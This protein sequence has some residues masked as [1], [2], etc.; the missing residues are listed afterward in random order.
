MKQQRQEKILSIIQSQ[1]VTTQEEL[2][3]RLAEAGIGTKVDNA[4]TI[5]GGGDTNNAY[6]AGL[7]IGGDL[8]RIGFNLDFAPVADLANV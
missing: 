1:S 5:G 4:Q 2:Q 3:A 7:S 6:L 8:S